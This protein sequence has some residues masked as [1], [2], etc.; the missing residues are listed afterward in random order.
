[1]NIKLIQ[2][3][4]D[5]IESNDAGGKEESGTWLTKLQ[6]KVEQ[7]LERL[8]GQLDILERNEKSIQNPLFRFLEREVVTVSGLLDSVKA[9][10]NAVLDLCKGLRKQ[11]NVLKQQSEDLHAEQIPKQWRKYVVANIT[12]TAW[13]I[14]LVKRVEQL[15]RLSE[16]KDFGQSGLWFGG[17][18]FPEAYL[19]ATRQ[20]IAQQNNWSLEDVVLKFEI[21][22][23]EEQ[24]A[25]NDQGFIL[26]G[27][28]M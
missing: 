6:P 12:A 27:F 25:N 24:L 28:T 8:P 16:S 17:L 19:T 7:M 20:F 5:E 22:L 11:T 13:I 21:G 9:D 26:T 4:G 18:C 14:D 3:T 15:K 10:L 1:M 2:G 23:N